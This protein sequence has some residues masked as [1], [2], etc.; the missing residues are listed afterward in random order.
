MSHLVNFPY[1]NEMMHLYTQW[2]LHLK[3]VIILYKAAH[4]SWA[5]DS[6]TFFISHLDHLP[7][8]GFRDTFSY[9][10]NSVN[11][12][13]HLDERSLSHLTECQI[14]SQTFEISFKHILQ[15]AHL[16][17]GTA[18]SQ[19]YCR[20][21]SAA[22]RSWSGHPPQGASS[23]H[24]PCFYRLAAGFPCGPSRTFACD[25]H[26]EEYKW[27]NIV[28]TDYSIFGTVCTWLII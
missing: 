28:F 13:T 10:S 26:W 3:S 25:P 23:W 17:V 8:L 12:A 2:S 11:L 7:C 19:L 9:Y 20:R 21:L 4:R 16:P 27:S 15:Y 5:N 1:T 18:L 14:H 24:R 22:K 6:Y